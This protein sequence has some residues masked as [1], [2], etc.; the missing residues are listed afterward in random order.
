METDPKLPGLSCLDLLA[1]QYPTVEA[2]SAALVRLRAFLQLPKGTEYYF[3]DLHGEHEAFIHLLRSASGTIRDK[4]NVIHGAALPESDLDELASLIFYPEKIIPQRLALGDSREWERLMIFRLMP[5]LQEVCR[6]YAHDH[7]DALTSNKFHFV[8]RE[9]MGSSE[10]P[11]KSV[12]YRELIAA[13]VDAGI[14]EG[15]ISNLCHQIQQVA[16]D[17]LHIIGDI[18]DRGPGAHRILDELMFHHNVDIQWGNHDI[19]W[20]GAAAGNLVC[21]FSVLRKAI[22]YNN[23]DTL[24][25]GY[26]INLRPLSMFA[27]EV[28][29]GDPCRAFRPHILD[30]SKYDPVDPALAAKMHKAVAIIMFKLEGQLI[31]RNPGFGL[32]HR[33]LLDKLDLDKGVLRIGDRAYPLCDTN[34]PTLD[35][36]DPYA[37][38]DREQALVE[39][40][41]TSFRHSS[42]LKRHMDFLMRRGSMYKAINGNLLYHGCIPMEADGSF[43]SLELD[44]KPCRGRAM[45]DA[46]D[47]IVRRAYYQHE[48][49]CVDFMWYLWSGA[50]SPL[51]GKARMT[52]FERYFVSKDVPGSDELRFEAKDPYY[53]LFEREDTVRRILADFGLDPEHSHIINGHVP[54]KK[55]ESPIKCG[56]R[57]FVIDGG[58]SKAYQSTTGIAGYTLIFN[59]HS[60]TLAEHRPF[61]R[62]T[63]TSIAQTNTRTRVVEAMPHRILMGETDEGKA[64]TVRIAALEALLRSYRDGLIREQRKE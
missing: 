5:V 49:A 30:E 52:T 58:I 56:G 4:I 32:E 47:G 26:G 18:Y 15:L 1:E 8:I 62:A 37:L 40:L 36:A 3:S 42:V 55:G 43:S 29:A 53:T 34:F 33:L 46:L 54:V 21:L 39:V 24:E 12:Y 17:N 60:L 7:V 6:K 48:P 31:R 16:V 61:Q 27:D 11:A 2:A 25:D 63:R 10:D 13:A 14:G 50:K 51:F 57:L 22:S 41:R 9:L 64:L 28:Y 19:D 20:I 44:G 38:T 23:F 59:S 35:P 45:L